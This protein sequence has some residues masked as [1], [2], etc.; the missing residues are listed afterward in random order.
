MTNHAKN[1]IPQE[2]KDEVIKYY[3]SNKNN[4]Q[5]AMSEKFGINKDSINYIIN[6]YFKKLK[7]CK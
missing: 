5:Q 1:K 7:P 6:C 4:T 3:L 2:K